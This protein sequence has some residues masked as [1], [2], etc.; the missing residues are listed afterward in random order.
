VALLPEQ[1]TDWITVQ[2][3]IEEADVIPDADLLASSILVVDDEPDICELFHDI[4]EEAGFSNV[5]YA[6]DGVEGLAKI[7]ELRPDLVILDMLMPAMDGLEVLAAVRADPALD[8]MPIIVDTGL[9][10]SKTRNDVLKAGASNIINKPVDADVLASLVRVHL[11][12]RILTASLKAYRRRVREELS[13]AQSM[14]LQLLPDQQKID[15]IQKHYGVT[16]KSH[17][18]PSSELGGDW[19]GVHQLGVSK[20]A[21]FN[22]DFAGHGVA[23]AVNTFRLHSVMSNI[24]PPTDDP[25]SYLQEINELLVDLMPVEQFATM[26]YAICDIENDRIIYSACAA[27]RPIF[28]FAQNPQLQIGDTSGLPLGLLKATT[29]DN[30]EV[31]FGPGGFVLIYSDALTETPGQTAPPLSEV[32]LSDMLSRHVAKCADDDTMD[33][34]LKEFYARSVSPVP[35]DLT[36]LWLQRRGD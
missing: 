17:F 27:P 16:L 9:D 22:V 14:Q 28:G 3:M 34:I 30:H 11:E 35:D 36:T 25:A 6:H 10:S 18:H 4:L 19:W 26:I 32:G 31:P 21:M 29:Y 33:N 1:S 20:F 23:A 12:R 15:D 7:R 13:D 24:T 8:D 5:I 2:P